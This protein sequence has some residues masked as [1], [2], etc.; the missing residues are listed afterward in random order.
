MQCTHMHANAH[1]SLVLL[2][3]LGVVDM[4]LSVIFLTF[5]TSQIP[6]IVDV[7]NNNPCVSLRPLVWALALGACLGGVSPNVILFH[8]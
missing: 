3:C 6:V 5:T 4:L 8:N 2:V 1:P 7:A